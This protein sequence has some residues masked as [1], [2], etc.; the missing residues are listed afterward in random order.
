MVTDQPLVFLGAGVPGARSKEGYD[1]AIIDIEVDANGRGSG[2]LA[3]A[4][5]VTLK[6]D[7]FVVEDYA[8]EVVRLTGVTKV[9]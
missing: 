7:A 8:S 9:K 6:Q 3:P 5:K 2:T 1:F 4:A